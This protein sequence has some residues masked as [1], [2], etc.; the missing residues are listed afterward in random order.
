MFTRQLVNRL[1]F[2]LKHIVVCEDAL[3]NQARI[4][5]KLHTLFGCQG[6]VQVSFVPGGE[7]AAAILKAG[8]PV[9]AILLDHDMPYGSGSDLLAWMKANGFAEKVKVLTFSGIPQNN[10]LMMKNGADYLFWYK[11]EVMDGV[12]DDLLRELTSVKE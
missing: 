3:D 6:H 12:A 7:M 4:A 2:P 9:D 8:I 5:E 10:D 11:H 1:T